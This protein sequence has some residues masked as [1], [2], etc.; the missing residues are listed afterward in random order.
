MHFT[1]GQHIQI[2]KKSKYEKMNS[3]N[4][5][6]IQNHILKINCEIV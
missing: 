5:P 6:P 1:N 4:G 2:H 3:K